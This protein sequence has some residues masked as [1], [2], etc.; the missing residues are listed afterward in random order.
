MDGLEETYADKISFHRFDAN[1][2]E[3]EVI[4]RSYGL[5]GHPGFVLLGP[6]GLVLWIG[7]GEPALKELEN[8][9]KNIIETPSP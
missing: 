1:S 9:L 8:Q 2:A 3:G 5:V 7:Q 6:D 4:F